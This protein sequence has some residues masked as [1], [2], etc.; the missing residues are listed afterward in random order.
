MST[1]SGTATDYLDLLDK[2][3]AFLTAQGH[4]WGK[5]F[6]G[7]GGGD[8]TGYIGKAAT[9]AQTITVTF[10]SATAFNVVGSVSGSL[11]SGAVGTPFT[12]SQVDFT[13]TAGAPAYQ[14]GDVWT[15]GVSPKWTR[16]RAEGSP[17]AASR[18]SDLPSLELLFDDAT[19]T[20][21]R[22]G[23][24]AF[25]EWAMRRATEVR[26]F[27]IQVAAA[28]AA[29]R[30]FSLQYRDTTGAA[31]TTAQSWSGQSWAA[32][33]AKEFSLTASAGA[34][35][36]WRL[37]I[38]A[39]TDTNTTA[40]ARIVRMRN[41]YL[42]PSLT[43]SYSVAERFAIAWRGPGLDGSKEVHVAA[44]TYGSPGADVWNLGFDGFRAWD[45][46]KA[47]D[48]QPNG[49]PAVGQ[50]LSLLN[51]PLAYWIVANGQRFVL[52][53]RVSGTYQA[54]YC[55]FGLPYEPP[56][57]HAYPHVV[58]ASHVTRTLR[59]DST[60]ANFRTPV[61]PGSNGLAAFYPDAQWRQHT[62]R[63]ESGSGTDGTISSTLP[64]VW[65]ARL[66]GASDGVP[67][68]IRENP[69]GS[70]PLL[71]VIPMAN[72]PTL[73]HVWG[74]L[75]GLFWTTG[76]GTTSEATIREDRFDHLVF[77]NVFRT[78]VQHYAAVRLD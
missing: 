57:V 71:P 35:L 36:Y 32:D 75:D 51:A 21:E 54:A 12:S 24:S 30:D 11:G 78:G 41:V 68:F 42:F 19:T 69:D 62:N 67:S 46:T 20:T 26:R 27:V 60:S 18:S 22:A 43:A 31:W 28:N 72:T 2:L 37:N 33:E 45:A 44:R 50:W 47:V 52:V 63:V 23:D 73:R 10:T 40:S 15:F 25:I 66:L 34:H 64:A 17:D 58:A 65:P 49:S 56:S 76:F 74:E 4:A 53:V 6:T 1:T 48:A 59:Y 38:T 7:V 29:P 61:D 9:V 14:A 8:L 5:A 13:I 39:S 16:L 70:R 77:G 3:D 55:G